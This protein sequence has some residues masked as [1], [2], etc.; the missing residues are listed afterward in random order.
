MDAVNR[1]EQEIKE[2]KLLVLGL[3]K[4]PGFP[5]ELLELINL[6]T[7]NIYRLISSEQEINTLE[8]NDASIVITSEIK[9]DITT[10]RETIH[11]SRVTGSTK[12]FNDVLSQTACIN[13]RIE[14]KRLVDLSKMLT[15]NDRFRFQREFFGN[16]ADSFQGNLSSW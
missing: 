8:E 15:L 12:T 4:I 1:L 14:P 7:E 6:R 5:S 16:D 2:L 10:I 13:D 9:E 11:E 3:S